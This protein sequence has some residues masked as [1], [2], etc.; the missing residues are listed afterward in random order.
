MILSSYSGGT[1]ETLTA[2][3]QALER[4]S[5]CVA[6]TSG[7]K[8]GSFYAAEGV[9]IIPVP[10]GL[11]PRAA[12]LR[13]LVPMVVV[14]DRMGVVPNLGS[15][16][17][18]ARE[19]L[20]TRDLAASRRTCPRSATPPS[21]SPAA[22]TSSIPLIWGAELTAPVAVPLEGPAQRE[23]QDAGLRLGAAG[24]RPQ[25]DL[26]LLRDAGRAEPPRQARDAARPPP[27]PP[28]RSGAST[29]PA[30]WS[31]RTSA[32]CSR[33]PPRGRARSRACSTW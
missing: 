9:P 28:G 7:G 22:L 6:I 14:L 8:L 1:E 3:S 2:A 26:R 20:A 27:P 12:L 33:S 17:E 23:R 5:L 29:S 13:L 10:P 30:S 19:T 21:S 16:L 11:Q 24:A 31:S 15:D 32:R 25:R 4:N 18:E